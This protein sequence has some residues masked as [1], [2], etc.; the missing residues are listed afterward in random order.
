MHMK[1]NIQKVKVKRNGQRAKNQGTVDIKLNFIC[2]I[3]KCRF[4][5]SGQKV[6]SAWI[7]AVGL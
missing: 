5:R 1:L 6:Q 3:Q 2:R 7:E 4:A